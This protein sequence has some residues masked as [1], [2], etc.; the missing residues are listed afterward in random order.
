MLTDKKTQLITVKF[1]HGDTLET[2]PVPCYKG[3]DISVF[4]KVNICGLSVID[5][6][7]LC[8][9]ARVHGRTRLYSISEEHG[10]QRLLSD[11]V[12]NALCI[13][14]VANDRVLA[15]YVVHF[16]IDESLAEEK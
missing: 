8:E 10:A 6:H 13:E 4:D 2:D 12:L 16:Y 3:G 7:S 1:H 15:L 9:I 5:L 11:R 14:A